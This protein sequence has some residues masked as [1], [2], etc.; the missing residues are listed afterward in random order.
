MQM[1]SRYFTPFAL[2]L[3]LS[4]VHFGEPERRT[5][6]IAITI[7]AADVFV[8]WWITKNQYRWI[9]WAGRFRQMQVWLNLF[10]AAPLFYLLYPYWGP[11][12]LLFVLA[13]IGRAHV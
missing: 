11:M 5:M 8:N 3:I 12:W 7:L 9:R 6:K 13:Q 4:A 10:W 1:L 2:I